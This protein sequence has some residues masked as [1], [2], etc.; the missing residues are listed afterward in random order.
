MRKFI[1]KKLSIIIPTYN[2]GNNI[3]SLINEILSNLSDIDHEII[4]VDDSS[5]DETAKLILENYNK[6]EKVK[7]IQREHDRGLVQSIK[8]ALQTITGE[9]FLVMDGDGQHSPKDILSLINDL[10]EKDLIIGIRDLNN[11]DTISKNRVILSKFFNK[12]VSIILK[13]Q[14]QDPLTGFFAGKISLLNKKFFLLNNSGFKVLLDLIFS[15]KKNNIKITEKTIDFRKRD[16]GSSKLSSQVTFSF[17]TQLISYLFNG[18]I[19]SKFIGFAIIGAFGFIFHFSFLFLFLN[20]F[21]FSFYL[22]HILATLITATINFILNNYLNFYDSDIKDTK[23]FFE[24]L[25]K[26]YLINIPAI[27]SSIGG[28]SFAFNVLNKNPFVS[29]LIGVILDTVFKYIISKTWIWKYR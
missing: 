6:N 20:K 29:S 16:S 24:G 26:Y 19:S 21:L 27:L 5:K 13:K 3:I 4:I 28:A 14:L 18:L 25:F 8:F 1:P 11:L 17:F 23:S 15:N 9:K 22:S 7:I 10:G 2:E 12:I